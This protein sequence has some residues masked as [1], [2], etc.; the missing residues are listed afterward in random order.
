MIRNGCCCTKSDW[1]SFIRLDALF[2]GFRSRCSQ[3]RDAYTNSG[4]T[5]AA[6]LAPEQAQGCLRTTTDRSPRVILTSNQVSR[7]VSGLDCDVDRTSLL[8]LGSVIRRSRS[9]SRSKARAAFSFGG[10]ASCVVQSLRSR[11]NVKHPEFCCS[12]ATTSLRSDNDKLRLACNNPST[13]S[14]APPVCGVGFER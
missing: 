7:P 11:L 13:I 4:I 5:R 12:R 9:R 10:P 6:N 14:S 8:V 1:R 2:N 3:S